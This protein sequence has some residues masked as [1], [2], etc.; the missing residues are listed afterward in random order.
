M[1]GKIKKCHHHGYFSKEVKSGCSKKHQS[2]TPEG[3]VYIVGLWAVVKFPSLGDPVIQERSP[4]T[5]GSAAG[6]CSE[7]LAVEVIV[8]EIV[9]FQ[10]LHW[11][12][13]SGS[14]NGALLWQWEVLALSDLFPRLISRP[15][16]LLLLPWEA[17]V[18]WQRKPDIRKSVIQSG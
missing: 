17:F 7:I 8:T 6:L 18:L 10:A 12:K 9:A 5:P 16:G 13:A 2:Q 14:S 4:W 15:A 1:V 3:T 11:G